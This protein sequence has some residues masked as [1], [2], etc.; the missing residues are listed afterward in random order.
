MNTHHLLMMIAI[1]WFTESKST[2]P[3][4]SH[5]PFFSP[6]LFFF[7]TLLSKM[8]VGKSWSLE[9]KKKK[10]IYGF[11]CSMGKNIHKKTY[12]IKVSLFQSDWIQEI[13]RQISFIFCGVYLLYMC[14]CTHTRYKPTLLL[15]MEFLENGK[16]IFSKK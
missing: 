15:I 2:T 3:F 12:I 6:L 13:P 5:P 7:F 8:V 4:I 9:E 1:M 14:V 11:D 16:K 10:K